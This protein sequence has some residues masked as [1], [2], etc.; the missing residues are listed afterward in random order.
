MFSMRAERS[1]S[2]GDMGHPADTEA[3]TFLES[4]GLGLEPGMDLEPGMGLGLG[5]EPGMNLEPGMGLGLGV[6]PALLA[7]MDTG[8]DFRAIGFSNDR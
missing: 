2:A 7:G 6:E 4:M 1:H 8:S 5:L 3:A